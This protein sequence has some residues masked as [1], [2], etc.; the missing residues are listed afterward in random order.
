MKA[1]TTTL[2]P[3]VQ[4]LLYSCREAEYT[5]GLAQEASITGSLTRSIHVRRVRHRLH[6]PSE[7]APQFTCNDSTSSLSSTVGAGAG[8]GSL[9]MSMLPVR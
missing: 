9:R 2:M 1:V 7:I 4:K 5:L 3:D 6:N 8:A